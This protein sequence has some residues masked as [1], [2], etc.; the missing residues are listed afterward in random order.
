MKEEFYRIEEYFHDKDRKTH[1][2]DRKMA[3][4]KDRSK[5]K[6][7]DQEKLKKRNLSEHNDLKKGRVL[8]IRPEGIFVEANGVIYTCTLKG[9]L[10]HDKTLFKNLVAVGDFV[11]ITEEGT[12]AFIEE[13]HSILSRADN[14][15]QRKEQLIA[16]NI[17]QVLITMSVVFPALKTNLIDRYI[18]ATLKGNMQPILVINKIDLLDQN[19]EEVKAEK[20]LFEEILKIYHKLSIPVFTVSTK[21]GS[22]IE[23]LKMAMQNKSSVFSGQSGVGKS[24]LINAIFDT[25]LLIGE[26]VEKTNKGSHTTTSAELIPLQQGGFCIDTPGIKSFGVWDLTREELQTFFSEIEE[27]SQKCRFPNCLHLQEPDCAVKKA[28]EEG[29]ISALRFDSYCALMASLEEEHRHR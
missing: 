14:L 8:S 13:R 5:Y 19:T 2:K 25:N 10:K 27:F 16:V 3:T 12:I 17:D 1:R 23:D 9:S 18:I 15:S 28:V 29:A 20:I 21:T 26:V 7:T 6:K 22:G 4:Q 11:R 24:S